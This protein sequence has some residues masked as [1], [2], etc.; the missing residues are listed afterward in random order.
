MIRSI[1]MLCAFVVLGTASSVAQDRNPFMG[2]YHGVFKSP[3]QVFSIRAEVVAEGGRNYRAIFFVGQE[4]GWQA[5]EQRVQISGTSDEE[6][7]E[8]SFSGDLD[9]GS[10]LG[11]TYALQATIKQESFTGTFNNSERSVDFELERVFIVPPTLGTEPPKGAMALFDGHH[12]D[13]WMRWPNDKW[14]L[15]S[16]G[17]MEVCGS[18]LKTIEEF[19][20]VEIHIEFRTPLMAHARG[21]A[22]GNSGVYVN[23]RYEIQV[24]DSFGELP[25]DN[26]CGGIYQISAPIVNA[27][28]PPEEWQT[29]DILYRAPRFDADGNK[30]EHAIITV[31]H[32]GITIHDELVMEHATP[33][34][35]SD[36]ESALGPL[37]LQDHGDRVAFRNIWIRPLSD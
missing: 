25:R 2:N 34:G 30:T 37:L 24:L 3:Y 13:H 35:I 32:N 19:G 27:S 8:L 31:V 18:N 21:Q 12:M 1:M 9:F 29:Y 11:G 33:G 10:S 28:L 7:T 26:F 5:L 20:D 15:T 16:D 14:C 36:Q 6:N 23:G 17:A 22:R 4:G